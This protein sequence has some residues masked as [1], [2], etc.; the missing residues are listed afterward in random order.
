M[1]ISGCRGLREVVHTDEVA[2][3]LIA[4]FLQ[5]YWVANK[6]TFLFTFLFV[7]GA[8]KKVQKNCAIRVGDEK[9]E[10]VSSYSCER[11]V[12]AMTACCW[13]LGKR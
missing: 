5:D 9:E 7:C 4:K 3:S 8:D 13:W 2:F 6:F 10:S 1:G 11:L 12:A